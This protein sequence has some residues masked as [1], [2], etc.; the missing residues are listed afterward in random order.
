MR[1]GSPA[2]AG[3]AVGPGGMGGESIEFREGGGAAGACLNDGGSGRCRG[4]AFTKDVGKI[5]VGA[6]RQTACIL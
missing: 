3:G 6:A 1:T 5:H 2:Q 4:S